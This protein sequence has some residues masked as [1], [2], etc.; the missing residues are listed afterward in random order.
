MAISFGEKMEKFVT[1]RENLKLINCELIGENKLL[2]VNSV[3]RYIPLIYSLRAT[4]KR[5]AG[6]FVKSSLCNYFH[7]CILF[8]GSS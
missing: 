6:F 1:V 7:A 5:S 3:E 8:E 2:Y 4:N